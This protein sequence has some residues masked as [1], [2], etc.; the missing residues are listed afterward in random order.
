M[1]SKFPIK[2]VVDKIDGLEFC[3]KITDF[4][5]DEELINAVGH[6]ATVNLINTLCGTKLQKNRIEI[7]VNDEDKLLIVS[8]KVRLEEGKILSDEEI[9]KMYEEGKVEFYKALVVRC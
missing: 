8:V 4:I 7:K 2:I 6:D 9:R 5:E 3:S 1:L